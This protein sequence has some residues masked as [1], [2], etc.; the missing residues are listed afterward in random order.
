M[1]TARL[2]ARAD[3][4]LEVQQAVNLEV[5]APTL[6]LQVDMPLRRF[7]QRP[8]TCAISMVNA[9][10][11]TARSIELAAQLPPGLKFVKANNAGWHDER[12][13]RVLWNLEE[14]PAGETG[15]VEVVVMPIE[16]GPQ[17]LVAAA[18]SPSPAA[19]SARCRSSR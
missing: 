13:H 7:L 16:L 18:R 17:K 3:G 11:A 12:T 10:T 6:E 5:T 1:H 2:A 15:S 4:G 9:G 8:A 19:R 14:L